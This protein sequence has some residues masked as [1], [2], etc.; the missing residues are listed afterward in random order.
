M[1]IHYVQNINSFNPKQFFQDVKGLLTGSIT[2]VA[3]LSA[4]CN[5]TTSWIKSDPTEEPA[6]EYVHDYWW[7]RFDVA[8]VAD[9]TTLTTAKQGDIA[10]VTTS[11]PTYYYL[12]NSDPTNSA[13]WKTT[14]VDNFNAIDYTNGLRGIFRRPLSDGPTSYKYMTVSVGKHYNIDKYGFN[15]FVHD[16]FDPNDQYVA[17]PWVEGYYWYGFKSTPWACKSWMLGGLEGHQ[18]QPNHYFGT[19]CPTD[20]VSWP[21]LNNFVEM[22]MN[23]DAFFVISYYNQD[24]TQIHGATERTRLGKW[25][26]PSFNKS[27]FGV[28]N[29]EHRSA[30]GSYVGTSGRVLFPRFFNPNTTTWL[31]VNRSLSYVLY[32]TE[33]SFLGTS[34]VG[35]IYTQ[36]PQKTADENALP[37]YNL[38]EISCTAQYNVNIS[39]EG[40]NI[41]KACKL[42]RISSLAGVS[43]EVVKYGLD[44]YMIWRPTITQSSNQESLAIAVKI[45]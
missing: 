38:F 20:L 12:E 6:W 41:S 32:D 5:K 37:I 18:N 28:F 45:S 44:E 1:F 2:T 13:S 39:N 11:T 36:N 9:L 25:D 35:D 29:I 43:G 16:T 42:Y 15:I 30:G 4:S 14:T 21:T 8:S 33:L 31:D 34:L 3:Q 26:T 24:F 22:K 40:G 10:R 17:R 27:I 19:Y 7:N 23:N